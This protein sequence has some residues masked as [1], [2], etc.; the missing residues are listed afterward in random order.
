MYDVHYIK[1]KFNLNIQKSC[2]LPAF[3]NSALR[4]GLGRMLMQFYCDEDGKCSNC[5][6][7]DCIV[8][9][10]MYPNFEIKPY[11][12]S[13]N[14]SV[15]YII[16]CFDRR[17]DFNCNDTLSFNIILFGKTIDEVKHII[18]AFDALGYKGLSSTDGKYKIKSV[19]D[20]DNRIIYEKGNLSLENINIKVIQEYIDK[21]KKEIA[22]LP[23]LFI[24]FIS[25]FRYKQDGHYKDTL[26]FDDILIALNRR[27]QILN[28][29]EGKFIKEDITKDKEMIVEANI[30]WKEEVRYSG[31]QKQRLKIGGIDGIINTVIYKE[32]VLDLLIAGELVHIGKN[33]SFGLGKYNLF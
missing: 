17:I 9:R 13:D 21:R 32:N 4:G 33:T 1:L 28:C 31:R 12:T 29:F 26:Q 25:P 27:I 6:D 15:G 30:R 11:F 7:K 23:Q 10:I 3:K 24:N 16:E 20:E 8:K 19:S 22:N 5:N 2:K 18:Y 14:T